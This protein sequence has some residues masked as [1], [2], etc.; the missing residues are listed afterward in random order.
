MTAKEFFQKLKKQIEPLHH[1]MLNLRLIRETYEGKLPREVLK[2]YSRERYLLVVPQIRQ[3]A[4]VIAQAPDPDFEKIAI[5]HLNGE[6]GHDRLC[7]TF[8]KWA[9]NSDEELDTSS[10]IFPTHASVS[11]F[12]YLS[13]HGKPEETAGAYYAGEGFI[14]KKFQLLVDGLKNRYGAPEEALQFFRIHIT[15]DVKHSEEMGS[16]VM[17]KYCETKEAQERAEYAAMINLQYYKFFLSEVYDH[18]A[19]GTKSSQPL[20]EVAEDAVI[21]H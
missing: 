14:P 19:A 13:E 11:F 18:Y 7:R 2:G 4:A 8:A 1:E 16:A 3:L 17:E 20:S 9:G 6:I 15:E 12:S 10:P 5:D 21:P